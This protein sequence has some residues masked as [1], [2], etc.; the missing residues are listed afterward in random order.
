[1]CT[2]ENKESIS[3]YIAI[4]LPK[5]S[6]LH[7]PCPNGLGTCREETKSVNELLSLTSLQQI[8][9]R[10]P[11]DDSNPGNINVLDRPTCLSKTKSF[12]Q[13]VQGFKCFPS[14]VTVKK[15]PRVLNLGFWNPFI[16]FSILPDL[17]ENRFFK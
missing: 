9:A 12:L 16:V 1:M 2:R 5:S 10:K 3:N 11:E 14:L 13:Q 8:W 17:W 15:K 7:L 4:S 6:A